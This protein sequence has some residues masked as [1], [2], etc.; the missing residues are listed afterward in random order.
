MVYPTYEHK[1]SEHQARSYLFD[2]KCNY[3]NSTD[4]WAMPN[5]SLLGFY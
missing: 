5:S 2:F 1:K 4:Y 3:S